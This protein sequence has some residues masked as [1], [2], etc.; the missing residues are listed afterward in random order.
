MKK[1]EPG[2]F[3]ML[4]TCT[5]TGCHLTAVT[6]ADNDDDDDDVDNAGRHNTTTRATYRQLSAENATVSGLTLV[7]WYAAC[8]NCCYNA[9]GS[10]LKRR[11]KVSN[12]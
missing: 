3:V 12:H 7:G 10:V 1:L 11:T 5:F 9:G 2:V 8:N 4:K 6:N